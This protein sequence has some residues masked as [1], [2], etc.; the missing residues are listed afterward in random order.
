[1]HYFPL[2]AAHLEYLILEP[3]FLIGSEAFDVGGILADEFRDFAFDPGRV[4][5]IVLYGIR[6]EK[7][8]NA[9]AIDAARRIIR[10]HAYDDGPLPFPRKNIPHGE[11]LDRR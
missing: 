4:G 5:K 6:R 11:G 8:A 7:A 2:L 3:S 1:M 9:D 10:R